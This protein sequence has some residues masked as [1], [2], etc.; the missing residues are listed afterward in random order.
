MKKFLFLLLLLAVAAV[1]GIF[2]LI[3]S[4][5]TIS[6]AVTVRTTDV[7]AERFVTDD[8]KWAR[9]WHYGQQT[10]DSSTNNQAERVFV[11]N[12]YTFKQSSRFYKS[13]EITLQNADRML[14]SKMVVVPLAIDSTGIEWK[15]E[16]SAGNNPY[17]RLMGYLEAKRIKKTMDEVI[18]N[19]KNF[20]SKTE[21]VY[22][23]QIE[24]N[25]LK[26]TL[27]VSSKQSVHTYPSI[28]EVYALI[29]KI[30]NYIAKNGIQPSGNPIYNVTQMEDNKFQLMAAVPV[31]HALAETDEFAMKFMVK[32]SFLITE[33]VG[34]ENAVNTSY[35][36]LLAY[37]HD[38]RKTSMAM[39]FTMLVTDRIL[40]P[41]SSK[42]ITKLY[43]PVY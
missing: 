29:G 3:P 28:K 1:F 43:Q 25:Y 9:W 4:K 18:G 19:L 21:N 22:G 38:Y 36:N 17:S 33:V 41:D 15:S 14:V 23:I 7:G 40:Q 37:F 35:H 2:L 42:W 12:G 5:I 39:N 32:G 16:L 6:S 27:F 8:S 13:A 34:G 26:D 11:T 20:L 31:N 10:A 24:R 30:K